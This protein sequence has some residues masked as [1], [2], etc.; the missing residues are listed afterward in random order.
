MHAAGHLWKK[1]ITLELGFSESYTE[2][3]H[4]M[5]KN[6]INLKHSLQGYNK[7][8]LLNRRKKHNK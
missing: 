6:S 2:N 1:N 5:C 4:F 3:N 8:S 7:T